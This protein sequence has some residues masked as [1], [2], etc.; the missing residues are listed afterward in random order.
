MRRS[1]TCLVA[2]L[3]TASLPALCAQQRQPGKPAEGTLMASG[4]T[5]K[6]THAT[7]Y[8]SNFDGEADVYMI[9][10][11]SQVLRAEDIKKVKDG[12]KDGNTYDYPRPFM[13]LEFTK[14]GKLL[15]WSGGAGN[16]SFGRNTALTGVKSELKIGEGRLS[17]SASQPE[18]DRGRL[19]S[20]F[21]VRF[22][23]ALPGLTSQKPVG[24]PAAASTGSVSGAFIGN[25]QEAKL[26][27][28]R[29]RWDEPLGKPRSIRLVFTEQE[30]ATQSDPGLLATMKKL[31]SCLAI[32][33]L[34]D[35]SVADCEVAHLGHRG[36]SFKAAGE[37]KTS[38]FVVKDGQ[39][40]GEIAT[41]GEVATKEKKWEVKLKFAAPLDKP[42]RASPATT[43]R[44]RPAESKPT[45]SKPPEPKPTAAAIHIKDLPLPKDAANI[46][47]RQ[48]SELVT[49]TSPSDI[50]TLAAEWIRSLRAQRW[51]NDGA[52]IITPFTAVIARK[53]G[54]ATVSIAITPAT[55]GS[56]VK[57]ITTGLSWEEK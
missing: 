49:L 48:A 24:K 16:T 10:L 35:G 14:E 36:L 29:A 25:G 43:A 26:A 5:Y 18:R 7:A 55:K 9:V 51:E 11:S 19:S 22:D 15:S 41:E 34:E 56:E 17:G 4:E 52:D 39:V 45:E 31:G 3:W 53:R 21:D 20:A 38:D 1:I 33:I 47:Y 40:S 37:V 32:S 27:H 42:K 2:A 13:K 6:L 44:P 54:S 46:E 23:V 12:E 30:P 57:I 8:E 50:K 28:V